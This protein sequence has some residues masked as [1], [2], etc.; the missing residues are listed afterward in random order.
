MN[1]KGDTRSHDEQAF[2]KVYN[3]NN[4]QRP[5]LAV[6]AVIFHEPQPGRMQLLLI[7][8]GAHP[9]MND[10]ALPGGFVQPDESAEQAVRRELSEEAGLVVTETQTAAAVL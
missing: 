6:D 10:W 5:S 1:S 4:Y 2:L 9:F 7:K 8:R 3:L